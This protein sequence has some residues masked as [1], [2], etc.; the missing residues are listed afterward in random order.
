MSARA[1]WRPGDVSPEARRAAEAAAEAAGVPLGEWLAETVRAALM[2][3]LGSLPGEPHAPELAEPGAGPDQPL[4]PAPESQPPEVE[5]PSVLAYRARRVSLEAQRLADSGLTSWLATRIEGLPKD[6]PPATPGT[7]KPAAPKVPSAP[8]APRL[9]LF[10]ARAPAAAAPTPSTASAP[11]TA[12]PL[13]L[14]AG[15]VTT[16]AVADLRPAR[17]RSR[18]ANDGDAAIS[19]LAASVAAQGVR[20][21]ILVRRLAGEAGTYEVVAGERRRLAAERVGR[22]D[23][24]AVIVEADDAEA[25][26]LS[27]AENLGRGDFS[28]L[29][30]GRVYLRL[31]TE[32]RVSAG[33]LAQR[34]A[35]ERSDIALAM[36]L[37]GL[38]AKVRQAIDG[39][40]LA[41]AQVY[42]LLNAP[43]PEAMTE[44]MIE[45]GGSSDA[46][47]G[48]A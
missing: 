35:R 38:P 22:A 25:L 20:E 46:A 33:L 34:L 6:P 43:D 39:G 14:P 3:E 5:P 12:L 7:S 30:E 23:L 28:P 44:R 29:D 4:S 26:M 42:A 45:S 31:L 11:E 32:Q 48:P 37:L 19:A 16:L 41:P 2:R 9:D 24:P 27:V 47:P 17:I 10:S 8:A 40:R 18:R 21:P 13:S 15:P 36:R 1:V